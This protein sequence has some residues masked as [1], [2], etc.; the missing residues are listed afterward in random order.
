M[1]WV[2]LILMIVGFIG[3]I[4][5]K[6]KQ[7]TLAAAQG[8]AVVFFIPIIVGAIGFLYQNLGDGEQNA[9]IANE[10]RF[11]ASRSAKVAAEVKNAFAGKNVVIIV[12]GGY[13]KEDISKAAYDALVK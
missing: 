8:L 6:K 4:I 9:L 3:I 13:D 1:F 11:A 5:C 2:Y 10:A 7:K 12:N